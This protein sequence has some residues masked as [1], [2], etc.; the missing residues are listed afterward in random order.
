MAGTAPLRG[1]RISGRKIMSAIGSNQRSILIIEESTTPGSAQLT[2][3]PCDPH[4]AMNSL[5]NCVIRA[6]ERE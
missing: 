5:A 6:F 1:V 4:S 3:T 2:R